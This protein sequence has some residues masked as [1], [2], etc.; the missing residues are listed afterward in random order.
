L[1]CE[2]CFEAFLVD[3]GFCPNERRGGFVVVGDE[4]VDVLDEF[5]NARER[6]PVERFS[7]EDREPDF[8]LIEPR[9]VRRR[10][11]KMDTS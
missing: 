6:L 8:D 11:V 1:V 10:V 5:W 9:G 7:G 3:L 2:T 4:G